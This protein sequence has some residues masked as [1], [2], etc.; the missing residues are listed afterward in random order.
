ME[1]SFFFLISPFFSLGVE[2]ECYSLPFVLRRKK[3]GFGYILQLHIAFNLLLRGRV[4]FPSAANYLS[5]H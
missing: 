2:K 5:V 1:Q 3:G 4:P